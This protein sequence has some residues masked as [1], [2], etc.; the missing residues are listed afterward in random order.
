MPTP[1]FHTRAFA[2]LLLAILC[3]PSSA[4]AQLTAGPSLTWTSA[5]FAEAM[6]TMVAHVSEI[7]VHDGGRTLL[8]AYYNSTHGARLAISTDAGGSWST[9]AIPGLTQVRTMAL[10]LDGSVLIGGTADGRTSPLIRLRR[11][12]LRDWSRTEWLSCGTG[13]PGVTLPLRTATTVWDIQVNTRGEAFIAAGAEDNDP[14]RPNV[15]VFSTLD[16]CETLIPATALA[17]QSVLALAI[18]PSNRLYAATS[19]TTEHD[20]PKLAGQTRIF[21]SDDHGRSWTETGRPLGAAKVYHLMIK[22][23]GTMLAGTGIRGGLYSSYDRGVTWTMGT[24]IPPVDKLLGDGKTVTIN[25]VTRIYRIIELERG[26]ILVGTG[27]D[28]GDLWLSPNNGVT[29]F[30]TTPA[31]DDISNVSWTIVK[32]ADGTLWIGKGSTHGAIY[33]ATFVPPIWPVR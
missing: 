30:R 9:Q 6:G 33:R 3:V 24:P 21:Y 32:A 5:R 26:W 7:L 4:Q 23:D 14:T 11:V 17:T 1:R 16:R 28:V 15:V 22:S 18:D 20:D 13:S 2:G 25:E 29:W 8:A 27:N 31:H 12:T 19:D 10:L